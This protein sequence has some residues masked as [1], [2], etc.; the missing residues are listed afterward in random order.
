MSKLSSSKGKLEFKQVSERHT[1]SNL[2]T[3]KYAFKSFTLA[4][5]WAEMLRNA[6][7]NNN[8]NN[9]NNNFSV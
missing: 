2:C 7:N 8:N 5:L 3:A 4:K 9:N 1:I 6:E